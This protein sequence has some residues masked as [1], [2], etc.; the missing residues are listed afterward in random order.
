MCGCRRRCFAEGLTVA[1]VQPFSFQAALLRGAH[2]RSALE[3][4]HVLCSQPGAAA[5]IGQLQ[6]A[7]YRAIRAHKTTLDYD[8]I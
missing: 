3:A 1:A 5:A 4:R 7:Q 6:L 8:L 2:L